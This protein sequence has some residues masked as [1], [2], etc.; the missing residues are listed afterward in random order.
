M[1]VQNLILKFFIFRLQKNK[2]SDKLLNS[3]TVHSSLHLDS[4]ILSLLPSLKYNKFWIDY[5]H[6]GRYHN[7]LHL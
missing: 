6:S 1:S 5:L 3:K 7:Y 2:K 4:H